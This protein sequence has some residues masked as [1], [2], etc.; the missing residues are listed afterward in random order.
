MGCVVD[1]QC[2]R[3]GDPGDVAPDVAP[4]VFPER[5]RAVGVTDSPDTTA[6]TV[7]GGFVSGGGGGVDTAPGVVTGE[8]VSNNLNGGRDRTEVGGVAGPGDDD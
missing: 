1:E 8:R 7:A 3:S 2:C 5:C 4:D 6:S